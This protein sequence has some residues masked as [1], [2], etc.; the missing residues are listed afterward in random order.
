MALTLPINFK[1]DIQDK[2]TALVPV[3]QIGNEEPLFI[4][5]NDITIG[6][7]HFKPLLLNIPSLKESIDIEKRNYKISNINID[8]SNYPY[9]GIRFSERITNSLI[10]V[11]CYVAWASPSVTSFGDFGA[12]TDAFL[13]FNGKIRR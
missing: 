7:T 12:D 11:N 6:D 5:T 10:N 13:V 4:S 3:M 2:D 1:A 8:I 9:E